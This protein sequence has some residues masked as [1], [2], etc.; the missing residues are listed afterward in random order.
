MDAK[1]AQEI[2]ASQNMASVSFNGEAVYI[3]H[4]DQSNGQVTIHPLSNP[5]SK[6]SVAVTE[7]VEQ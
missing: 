7:L 6:Q 4:V 1:R 2:S 3:E 5:S